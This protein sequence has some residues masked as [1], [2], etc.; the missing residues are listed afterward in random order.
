[1]LPFVAPPD[2]FG[3]AAKTRSP[4]KPVVSCPAW[5][6]IVRVAPVPFAEPAFVSCVIVNDDKS[7]A[8]AT[9]VDSMESTSVSLGS[10]PTQIDRPVVSA[11]ARRLV[12]DEYRADAML[13]GSV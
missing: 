3:P 9:P 13:V 5:A 8:A 4:P 12:L 10:V 6:W 2:A 7:P 1:M 11:L